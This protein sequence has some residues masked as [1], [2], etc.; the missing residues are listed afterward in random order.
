[1]GDDVRVPIDQE[2]PRALVWIDAREA[3][4]VRW[5]DERARIVRVSSD[6]PDRHKSLG[7]VR[8]DPAIRHG[9]GRAQD[10][11]ESRR[12]EY[13]ARFL[14][15]VIQRLPAGT[16]LTV[17]GPGTVHDHLARAVRT[18]DVEHHDVRVVVGRR[19][20]RMTDRQL[21]GLLRELEGDEAP[22]RIEDG[23]PR[24]VE[25]PRRSTV[26]S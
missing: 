1:M 20:S 24:P 15:D 2:R 19:S 6:V 18:A 17:L 13:L 11:E 4:I 8:H 10:A 14:K 25:H 21:V 26:R 16:D 3:I 23:P 12:E 22:R 9:G 7:H 5:E